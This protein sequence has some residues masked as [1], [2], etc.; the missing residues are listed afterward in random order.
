M[1]KSLI[2]SAPFQI[3]VSWIL[4][5]YMQFCAATT[6]WEF[7]GVEHRDAM[8]ESGEGLCG[9][10]WHSR[11]AQSFMGW[12]PDAP[13]QAHMLISRSREGEFISRFARHLGIGVVR[14]SSRNERK[15]KEKGS[16][17]AFR[18]MVRVVERKQGMALTVDGPRGP[19]QRVSMGVIKLAQATGKPILPYTWSSTHKIVSKSW[20]RFYIPLPFGKGIVIWNAPLPV[21]QDASDAQL[22]AMRVELENGLNRIT[23]EA[24]EFT[25]GPVIEPAEP[26]RS[27][28]KAA[29]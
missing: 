11:I 12:R 19:R 25:G 18:E 17:S 26:R 8:I 27:A 7:R 29:D 13:Q 1:L 10:F 15:S 3:V 28:R 24:D 14:G 21:P 4:A 2:A 16:L 6:R 5:K 9:A 22:E 20:D 23:Q